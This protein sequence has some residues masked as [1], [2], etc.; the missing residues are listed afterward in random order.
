MERKHKRRLFLLLL[1]LALLV[2]ALFM[3]ARTIERW[4]YPIEYKQEIEL[5]AANHEMNPLLVAAIIRSESNYQAHLVSSKG[6]VGLMQVMPAT[7][8]WIANKNGFEP[9]DANM[10]HRPVLNI[11]I[12]TWYL[13]ALQRQFDGNQVAMIAAYNAG[14]GNVRKWLNNGIWDGQLATVGDIPFGETRHYVQ[15]VVYYFEK[16]EKLYGTGLTID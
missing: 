5:S 6:A 8:R 1:T 10:L 3:N 13:Q 11:E 12:G 4:F 15:R 2:T 9:P 16:Y 7:A 14:P